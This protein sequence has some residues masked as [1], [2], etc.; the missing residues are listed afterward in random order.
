MGSWYKDWF[1]SDFYLT[2]YSHRN[3]DDAGK[4]L[5]NVLKFVPAQQGASVLDA[6]C[7]AGRH[8]IYMASKGF[9]VTAFDLSEPLLARGEAK[10]KA[11]DLDIKFFKGDL[12]FIG[13][14]EKFDII[15]NLFTSFGYFESDDENFAF[16]RSAYNMMNEGGYFLFDYFNESYLKNHIVSRSEKEIEGIKIFE[17][18]SIKEG[19]IVKQ[20]SIEQNGVINRFEESVKLYST[21]E[22]ISAFRSIGLKDINK[23]GSYECGAFEPEN[24]ERL[25]I[26]FRK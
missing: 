16:I 24:S 20:I 14:K 6:A 22:I 7:G 26:I 17:E 2:V 5:D 1:A 11:L 18:R 10:A 19:R 4:F 15:L 23:F 13:L 12:R 8:S 25:I 9:R 21:E 3:D